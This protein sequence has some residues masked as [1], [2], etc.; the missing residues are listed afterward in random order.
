[1]STENA[2]PHSP[3]L[4][5]Y[6]HIWAASIGRVLQEVTGTTHTSQELSAEA[7]QAQVETLKENGIGVRFEAVQHLSGEHGFVLSKG[8][9]V[10]LAQ[11]LLTEPQDANATLSDDHRD[12]L[13]ELFRQFAGGAAVAVKGLVGGEVSFKWSAME[14]LQ[15]EP[16]VRVGI[17]WSSAKLEPF[18]IIV[19]ISPTLAKAFNTVSQPTA[20]TLVLPEPNGPPA[21]PAP[22]RDP[23]LELLMDVELAVTLRFGER[24][25]MLHEILDLNAGSVVELDQHIQD[26]VQ[27]LVGERVIARGEV[28]VVE[29]NYG[30][31]VMEILSPM[32]RIESLR[33]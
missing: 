4:Q 31:R 23:K 8:H 11:L 3:K 17:Q 27:L 5:E 26:P 20:P 7:T 15:G 24:Q 12:A 18:T 19:E 30:L 33:K 25:M 1:M 21:P 16:A 13:G 29:G 6:I 9:A 28:V 2:A 32:E 10:R 22:A 14:R